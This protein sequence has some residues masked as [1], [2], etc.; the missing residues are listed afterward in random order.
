[1]RGFLYADVVPSGYSPLLTWGLLRSHA[2]ESGLV[3]SS[4]EHAVSVT[5]L[6][7]PAEEMAVQSRGNSA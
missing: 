5:R 4:N 2:T 7:T 1:M 3:A 6:I